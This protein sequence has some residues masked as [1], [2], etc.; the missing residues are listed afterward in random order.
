M[1][2]M[3]S[4]LVLRG[5]TKKSTQLSTQSLVDCVYDNYTC[6]EGG[7]IE[8]AVEFITNKRGVYTEAS[9]PQERNK[10]NPCRLHSTPPTV[11]LRGLRG[12][13]LL[14][15][16]VESIKRLLTVHGPMI[17]LMDADG[18]STSEG[19]APLTSPMCDP[20]EI[21]HAV[22]L[23][24]YTNATWILVSRPSLICVLSYPKLI[25]SQPINLEKLLGCRMGS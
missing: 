19:L 18:L 23:V 3:E 22:V 13:T 17:L 12:T 25:Y 5:I 8:A 16:S 7:T 10:V 11:R 9:Y 2:Y 14:H 20:C 24:G 21:N 1:A 6:D 4:Q 15:S